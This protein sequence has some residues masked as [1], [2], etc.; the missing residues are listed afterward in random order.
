MD[1]GNG[2]WHAAMLH[3][4]HRRNIA[5][6]SF[7]KKSKAARPQTWSEERG[8]TPRHSIPYHPEGKSGKLTSRCRRGASQQHVAAMSLS[9]RT[10]QNWNL[11]RNDSRPVSCFKRAIP[12]RKYW[13]RNR[14]PSG[15]AT[16][17]LPKASKRGG[18][19]SLPTFPAWT[20]PW[21]SDALCRRRKRHWCAMAKKQRSKPLWHR[22][23]HDAAVSQSS[24][25]L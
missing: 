20:H 22:P 8:Q 6:E 21:N 9:R 14:D 3:Q 17:K 5:Q 25:I 19:P 23:V 18:A 12:N 15:A 10:N 7:R 2:E 11:H 4:A 1:A 13:R 16:A 24:D